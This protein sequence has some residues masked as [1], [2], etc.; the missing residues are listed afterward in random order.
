[1]S[2]CVLMFQ[3][4]DRMELGS[5]RVMYQKFMSERKAINKALVERVEL[6][7]NSSE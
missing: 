7:S 5:I 1:M 3:I 4:M 2:M 6:F